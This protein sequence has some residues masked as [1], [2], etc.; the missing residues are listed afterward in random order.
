MT[1]QQKSHQAMQMLVLAGSQS[2]HNE[3]IA[4]LRDLGSVSVV[5]NVDEAL[6]ALR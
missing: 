6:R 1:T 2:G 3:L 5:D 4:A